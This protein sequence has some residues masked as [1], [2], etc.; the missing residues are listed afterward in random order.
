MGERWEGAESY[1]ECGSYSS[2]LAPATV[3]HSRGYVALLIRHFQPPMVFLL[4]LGPMSL[5][6]LRQY[7]VCFLHGVFPAVYPI[8]LARASHNSDNYGF[9]PI[10]CSILLRVRIRNM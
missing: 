7:L 6:I 8:D 5:I 9:Q 4:L 3:F 2:D 1:L 10:L